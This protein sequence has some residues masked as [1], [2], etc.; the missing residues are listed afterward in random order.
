VT[1]D[2]LLFVA[3]AINQVAWALLALA[4]SVLVAAAV[5]AVG[6]WAEYRAWRADR[7][8]V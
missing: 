2:Q 6:Y 5:M 1:P 4:G 3:Q 8:K 7:D